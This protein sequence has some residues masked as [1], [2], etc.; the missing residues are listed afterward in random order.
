V[1]GALADVCRGK[2]EQL[3]NDDMRWAPSVV[4]TLGI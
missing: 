4:S 2:S 3:I 1:L